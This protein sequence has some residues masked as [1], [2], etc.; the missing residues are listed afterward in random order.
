MA[1][2]FNLTELKFFDLVQCVFL[3]TCRF[4]ADVF[5]AQC[6]SC[7]VAHSS[8]FHYAINFLILPRILA[9]VAFNFFHFFSLLCPNRSIQS[10][11]CPTLR[12][13]VSHILFTH[14]SVPQRQSPLRCEFPCS[15]LCFPSYLPTECLLLPLTFATDYS[16]KFIHHYS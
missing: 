3:I 8:A 1:M 10:S 4:I 12:Y 15:L 5:S 13:L 11:I 6:F 7:K 2:A 9:R 16:S 14:S